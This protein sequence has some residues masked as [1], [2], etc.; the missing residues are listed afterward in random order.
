MSAPARFQPVLI[1]GGRGRVEGCPSEDV[2]VLY[3]AGLPAG[4][5]QQA[6]LLDGWTL[7]TLDEHTLGCDRCRLAAARTGDLVGLL[8]DEPLDEPGTEFWD[9]LTDG[10]MR[11]IDPAS[12]EDLVDNVIPLRLVSPE[13]YPERPYRMLRTAVW[14]LAA[15]VVFAIGLGAWLERPP[16]ADEPTEVLE[17]AAPAVMESLPDRGAAEALAAEL[18]I[19]TEPLDLSAVAD[20]DAVASDLSLPSASMAWLVD[21]LADDDM[22]LL[23]L[24]LPSS[25]PLL[26]LIALDDSDLAEVLRSLE[27]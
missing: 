4:Q 19:S 11:S 20:N 2:L 26:D 9:D 22:E 10:V 8:R 15:T 16:T 12:S 23:D 18:G 24:S 21:G 14:A 1:P 25:D 27:S 7:A 5:D 6:E 17:V 3:G 13:P